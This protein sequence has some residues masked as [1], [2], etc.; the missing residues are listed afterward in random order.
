MTWM[1]MFHSETRKTMFISTAE[2]EKLFTL[3]KA[4]EVRVI[5]LEGCAIAPKA[6]ARVK[7]T[8]SEERKAHMSKV[9]KEI[10]ARKKAEK[11]AGLAA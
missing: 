1:T 3:I 7:R 11:M 10:H 8:V 9:M 6:P 5:E 4:L 2:K